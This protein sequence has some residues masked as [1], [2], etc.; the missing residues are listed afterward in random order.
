[1]NILSFNDYKHMNE[2]VRSELFKNGMCVMYSADGEQ[3]H[4]YHYICL[5]EKDD[6]GTALEKLKKTKLFSD[7]D[8]TSI[9][10]DKYGVLVASREDGMVYVCISDVLVNNILYI[11]DTDLKLDDCIKDEYIIDLSDKCTAKNLIYEK[12]IDYSK[13]VTLLPDEPYFNY[14][15]QP[16]DWSSLSR[17]YDAWALDHSINNPGSLKQPNP[18][19][20]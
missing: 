14:G 12:D 5:T 8:E 16:T 10:E 15:F 9:R 3:K 11:W 19:Y 1:M 20:I 7:T 18:L 4:Y 2:S 13:I 17:G 6:I